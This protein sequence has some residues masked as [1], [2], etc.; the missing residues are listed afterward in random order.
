MLSWQF[1]CALIALNFLGYAVFR[2]SNSQKDIF[3]TYP[4]D[5]RVAHLRTLQTE[6]G[7]RL[8]HSG[9]WGIARHIN[10]TGDWLMSLAW[11]MAC[12]FSCCV[13]YFYAAYFALLL[14]HRDMRDDAACRAKYGR[15]WD[16]YC[17]LVPYRLIPYVY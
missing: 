10:Y 11:C 6:R 3:R 16:R 13:P 4:L 5:P 14:I 17:K 15:D 2:G 8:I 1:A 9:W 7:T 12:G